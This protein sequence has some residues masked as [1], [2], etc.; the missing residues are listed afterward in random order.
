M[1]LRLS[2]KKQNKIQ[3]QGES[4]NHSLSP[5][6]NKIKSRGQGESNN[7]PLSPPSP[8][9]HAPPLHLKYIRQQNFRLQWVLNNSAQRISEFAQLGIG[10]YQLGIDS[11]LTRTI[12]I[13]LCSWSFCSPTL[14]RSP[15]HLHSLPCSLPHL[16]LS[17]IIW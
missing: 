1:D 7:H 12:I 16:S 3:G 9:I 14:S 11:I 8:F 10:L 13:C 17:K 4:N 6:K 15:I 5:R 2:R